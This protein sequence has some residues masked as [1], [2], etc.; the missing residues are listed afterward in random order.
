MSR[1][2]SDVARLG[3]AATLAGAAGAALAQARHARQVANDPERAALEQTPHGRPLTI[4][5]ADGTRLHAEQFGPEGAPALV[6]AHG[7]TETLRFWTYVLRELSGEFRI[8]A[9]DLRGHG[10]SS[11]APGGDYSITRFGD[12]LEAVLAATVPDTERAIVA[13]HSLGAMSIVAWAEDHDVSARAS[14]AALLFTGI[15]GLVAGQGLVHV[16][17]F[18]QALNEQFARRGLLGS[19]APLP[20]FSTPLTA[21]LVR[22]VAFGPDATPAQVAFYERMLIACPPDVRAASGLAM[23]EL[24]LYHALAHLTVPTL[25]MAGARDRLTPPAHARRIAAEL[26]ELAEL[27]VLPAT[28]HM[29]PLERPAEVSGALREL[30]A[31][32][33]SESSAPV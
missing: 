12:D 14:A 1:T 22:Y 15:G 5:S 11:K 9:Y 8:V 19:P 2:R 26:P 13:G 3:A 20:R 24:D 31:K 4:T 27:V 33:A 21:A 25:V 23:S 7:W 29:G 32:V 17:K 28:G 16:P 18:A 10:A 30:Q 6:L